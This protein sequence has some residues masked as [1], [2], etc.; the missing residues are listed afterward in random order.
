M[1][2]LKFLDKENDLNKILKNKKKLRNDI[3]ILFISLWDDYSSSL[4]NKL[5]KKYHKTEGEN[6]YI[7]DSFRMPHSFVIFSTTKVPHLIRMRSDSVVSEDYLPR[8]LKA[9]KVD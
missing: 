6:L 3:S 8:I 7:V 9:L 4:V 5:K 2:N 1:Y